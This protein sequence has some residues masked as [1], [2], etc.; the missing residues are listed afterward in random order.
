MYEENLEEKKDGVPSPF[1]LFPLSKS[2]LLRSLQG[3]VTFNQSTLLSFNANS[4]R[5]IDDQLTRN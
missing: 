4:N 2:V 3:L 5:S 1:L